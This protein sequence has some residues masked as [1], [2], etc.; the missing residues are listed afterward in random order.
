M[1]TSSAPLAFVDW[2]SSRD[3][4]SMPMITEALQDAEGDQPMQA[5]TEPPAMVASANA[6]AEQR[7]QSQLLGVTQAAHLLLRELF[8]FK[9]QPDMRERDFTP[10][11][12]KLIRFKDELVG[13]PFVQ[14]DMLSQCDKALVALKAAKK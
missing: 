9:G 11:V 14:G 5:A 1:R 13:S 6:T 7:Y 3:P 10:V 12:N 2:W 4:D 8:K